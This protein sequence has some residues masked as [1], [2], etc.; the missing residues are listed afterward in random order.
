MMQKL[1][2][3]EKGISGA[4]YRALLHVADAV[5]ADCAAIVAAI[6][7]SLSAPAIDT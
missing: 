2:Y 4:I 7:V 5:V 1:A 6:C 3:V